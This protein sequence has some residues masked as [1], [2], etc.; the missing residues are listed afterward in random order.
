MSGSLPAGSPEGSV[1][2]QSLLFACTLN[3]VRSPMA[4]ALARQLLPRTVYVASAGLQKTEIDGFAVAVMRETGLDIA[5]HVPQSLDEI[6][7]SAFDLVVA[8]TPEAAEFAR[9]ATRVSATLVEVWNVP[10]VTGQGDSREQRLSAYRGVREMLRG[11]IRD[12][13]GGAGR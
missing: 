6:D 10:D 1:L 12:R 5:E 3:A 9:A 13:F 7:C 8:L 4:E 2:P 11:L